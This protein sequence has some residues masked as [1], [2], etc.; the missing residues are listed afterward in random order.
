M[1][2]QWQRCCWQ[3]HSDG[4]RRKR[5]TMTNATA[6]PDTSGM[7]KPKREYIGILYCLPYVVV[8]LF[9]MIIPMFYALYL[10][11]FKQSLLGGTTFAGFDN[12]IAAFKDEALWSGFRRVLIYAAIQIPLNLILSL[13]AALILDSQ[14]IR[15]IA[16]PRILLFLPYAVPGVIAALMWGYIY[17][18]K[19]GLVGQIASMIG[20]T[21]P[22]M[23][24]EKLMLFA[25]ANICTW[26]SLGYNMLI[27]YSALIGIPNE[28]YES[29]RIDGASEL[30]IAWSVK[31]PQIKG[32]IMMTVL[33]SVIGTLQLFNE[34]SILMNSAPNVIT[35]NYTPNLYAYNLAFNGQNLNYAAAVSL[36]IGV[37]VMGLVA[38]VKVIGN[39]WENK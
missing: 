36:V 32:S 3:A 5:K 2:R 18:D 27:Y 14:R 11:F 28:L 15:H 4:L 10:S 17:G 25:I 1:K 21:A 16:V 24:S 20:A 23:L 38:V 22:N 30:R 8:F 37:I 39:K 12:F 29:A 34:P 33:F 13:A 19:Y 7:R 9:G 6:K 35:S 26:C 31:I